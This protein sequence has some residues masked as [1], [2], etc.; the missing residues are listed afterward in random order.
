M[1]Q[2]L[3]THDSEIVEFFYL[4]VQKLLHKAKKKQKMREV[5]YSALY[6]IT[7]TVVFKIEKGMC[8]YFSHLNKLLIIGISFVKY[9]LKCLAL[10]LVLSW[11]QTETF[12]W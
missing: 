6:L 3:N 7:K 4:L 2:V 8:Y 10:N 5:L 9:V 11:K 12:H 1:F